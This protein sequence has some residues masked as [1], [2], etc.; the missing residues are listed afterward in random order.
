VRIPKSKALYVSAAALV[1]ILSGTTATAAAAHKTVTVEDNGQR[2]VV[3]GFTFGSLSSFLRRHG[4]KVG[5]KDRVSADLSAD[6]QDGMTVVIESPKH[7]ELKDATKAHSL[8]TFAKTVG[9][10]LKDEHVVLGPEDKVNLPLAA[11]VRSGEEIDIV[12]RQTKISHETQKIPF[13]TIRRR[14]DALYVGQKRVLT[15]G[16]E[17]LLEVKTTSVYVNGHRVRRTVDHTVIKKPVNQIVEIGT[18][19]RPFHLAGRGVGGLEVMKAITVSATAY[20]AGG[21]TY[22]GLPAQPGVISVDPSVIPLGSR[23][24][25]PGFGVMIAA[26]RGTAIIGNRIDICMSTYAEAAAWGRRTITI[27][28]LK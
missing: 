11:P 12:R 4:V 23:V 9:E 27:Y 10:L 24:Y 25:I 17:G 2:R 21:R 8:D 28:V 15:H 6:V 22:S 18:R 26:D 7:I 20:P 3:R 19:Q 16:V 14:T 1:A 5:P 13:Q